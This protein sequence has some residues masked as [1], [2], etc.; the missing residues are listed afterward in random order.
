MSQKMLLQQSTNPSFRSTMN[1]K[2]EKYYNP[3]DKQTSLA[4]YRKNLQLLKLL[5]KNQLPKEPEIFQ[6]VA[7]KT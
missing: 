6:N 2:K 3:L 4:T 5:A 1:Q 7:F